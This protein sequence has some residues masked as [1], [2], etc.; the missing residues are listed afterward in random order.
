M[1]SAF[2]SWRGPWKLGVVFLL[3][4]LGITTLGLLGTGL[5]LVGAFAAARSPE[6]ASNWI[7]SAEGFTLVGAVLALVLALV[8]L[9]AFGVGA[10]RWLRK[11][12][13]PRTGV[14]DGAAS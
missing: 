9:A 7:T 14:D 2:K 3:S 8:A 6:P 11:R 10:A 13:P 12:L 5:S 1:A 4:S